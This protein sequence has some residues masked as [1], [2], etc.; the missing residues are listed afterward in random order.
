MIDSSNLQLDRLILLEGIP[1][2]VINPMRRNSFPAFRL[3]P[4]PLSQ[5]RWIAGLAEYVKRRHH[6]GLAALLMLDVATQQWMPPLLPTQRCGTEGASFRLEPND[7]QHLPMDLHIAGSFLMAAAGT[8]DEAQGLVPSFDGLHI[9]IESYQRPPSTHG[10]L[11]VQKQ[12]HPWPVESLVYDDW[13]HYLHEH[14]SRLIL[15]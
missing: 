15:A 1:A 11:R 13:R 6:C 3:P 7:L 10:F 14:S 4:F 8:L 12:I 2:P 5:S 9:I